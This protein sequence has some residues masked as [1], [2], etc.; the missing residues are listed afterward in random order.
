M[1]RKKKKLTGILLI[2]AA[3]TVA[4]HAVY[5]QCIK[6]EP[7]KVYTVNV[8]EPIGEQDVPKSGTALETP[9]ETKFELVNITD[10]ELEL[11]RTDEQELS[12]MLQDWMKRNMEYGNAVGVE[13]S[14][15]E[16][17]TVTEEKCSIMMKTMVEEGQ[18][19]E[20]SRILILD[21]YRDT[22][23]YNIHP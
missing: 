10:E 17:M 14:D 19:E 23:K 21:Y 11:F 2:A 13:F 12:D 16:E 22:D 18:N 5:R 1:E 3:F 20:E 4:G 15:R 7:E 6:E 9:E 8:E